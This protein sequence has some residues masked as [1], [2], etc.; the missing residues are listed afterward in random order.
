MFIFSLLPSEA[1][2]WISLLKYVQYF[3]LFVCS[4][5]NVSSTMKRE[6]KTGKKEAISQ[7]KRYNV[8]VIFMQ[9]QDKNFLVT[10]HITDVT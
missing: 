7:A 2:L 10:I 3:E 1:T 9:G 5:I 6:G 4:F 8:Y